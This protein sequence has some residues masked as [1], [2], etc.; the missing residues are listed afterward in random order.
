MLVPLSLVLL[1]LRRS[2]FAGTT[3]VAPLRWTVFCLVVLAVIELATLWWT[4]SESTVSALRYVGATAT[5]CPLMAVL[6]AKRPQNI[7][8]QFIVASLWGVLILPVGEM[9]VLW[10]GGEL[11]EGPARRWFVVILLGVGLSNY[12]LTRFG[13]AAL[14]ATVGQVLLLLPR[15]P[16]N[17]LA[18]AWHFSAGIGCLV[19]AVAI[20]WFQ[21]RNSRG[22][23]GWNRVWQDFRNAFG[24]VWGLRVMERVNATAKIGGWSCELNWFGFTDLDSDPVNTE[25]PEREQ[26]MRT[27]LR[28]FVSND[29]IDRRLSLPRRPELQDL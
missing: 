29:W 3:L 18:P 23:L 25:H 6:G 19:A 4:W 12:V 26:A 22:Q 13:I 8:W 1:Y 17:L 16:F 21:T 2:R 20:A 14:A 24:I 11:D 5:F 9:L 15:L 27:L 10:R 28:R 7:G